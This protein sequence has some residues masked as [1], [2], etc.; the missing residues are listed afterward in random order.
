MLDFA[1][2]MFM[3][4]VAGCLLLNKGFRIKIGVCMLKFE[5]YRLQVEF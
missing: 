5:G 2:S 4:H 3:L 1:C